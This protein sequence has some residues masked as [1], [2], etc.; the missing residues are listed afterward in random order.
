MYYTCMTLR[1]S[2]FSSG[3]RVPPAA[4]HGNHLTLQHLHIV[5]GRCSASLCKKQLTVAA[6]LF[7]FIKLSKIRRPR[8]LSVD[9]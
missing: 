5:P 8:A 2:P 3:D 9:P 1:P 7:I 6:G 4:E